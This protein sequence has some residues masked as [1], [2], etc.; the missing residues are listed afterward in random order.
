MKNVITLGHLVILFAC[1]E[2]TQAQKSIGA[3][4]GLKDYYKKYFPI[5]VAVMPSNLKGDEAALILQQFNSLTAENSMK[6]GPIHP[7]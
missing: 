3:S 1:M 7:T 4:K 5:G 2:S 6:M